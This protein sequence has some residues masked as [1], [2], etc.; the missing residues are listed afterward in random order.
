MIATRLCALAVACTVAVGLATC[1]GS[2]SSGFDVGAE[3]PAIALAL[4][5]GRCVER[6]GLTICPAGVVGASVPILGADGTPAEG[7]VQAEETDVV[8]CR[9]AAGE[10]E[11]CE[12]LIEFMPEGFTDAES[13]LVAVRSVEPKGGWQLSGLPVPADREGAAP[14]TLAAP[15]AVPASSR[16]VQ[17]AV[18]VYDRGGARQWAGRSAS[19]LAAS[20]ARFAFVL[21]AAAVHAVR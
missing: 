15:V 17:V 8:L 7:R 13:F 11:R 21:R 6:A 14:G 16:V 10:P 19:S 5:Q 3:D 9:I 12:A 1:G 2:G 4:E 20:G 18:L